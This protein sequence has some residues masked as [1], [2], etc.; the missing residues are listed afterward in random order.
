MA[1]I[2]DI[3]AKLIVNDNTYL[4]KFSANSTFRLGS[5]TSDNSLPL[6]IKNIDALSSVKFYFKTSKGVEKLF[7]LK[8]GDNVYFVAD[9]NKLYVYNSGIME[10]GI[11]LGKRQGWK[12]MPKPVAVAVV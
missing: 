1:S 6:V 10:Q 12:T 8:K 11:Y 4:H 5:L 3:F 7:M 2:E 9:D